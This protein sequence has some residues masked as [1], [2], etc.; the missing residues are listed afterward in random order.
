MRSFTIG[1]EEDYYGTILL[2]KDVDTI[3]ASLK[4]EI[5]SLS[6]L[7]L[8]GC[9]FT[10]GRCLQVLVVYGDGSTRNFEFH[11][12]AEKA[13]ECMENLISQFE[14]FT[15]PPLK[16]DDDSDS[17]K[18]DDD[19]D[20]KEEEEDSEDDEEEEEKEDEEEKEEKED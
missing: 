5:K 14:V 4:Y 2:S 10:L 17:K 15:M 11:V 8:F 18:E 12:P 6:F 13:S 1:D 20:D 3:T 7:S 9:D 16:K 19:E